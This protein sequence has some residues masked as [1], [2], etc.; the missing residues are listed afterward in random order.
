MVSLSTGDPHALVAPPT[1]TVPA[2]TSTGNFALTYPPT[3]KTANV[4]LTAHYEG[5]SVSTTVAVRA[6]PPISLALGASELARGVST[7]ATVT[8]NT[9]APADGAVVTLSS[10][11]SSA[12]TAPASVTL[13]AGAL[14]GSFTATGNYAGSP[15]TVTITAKYNGASASGS[16]DVPTTPVSRCT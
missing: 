10:T 13:P 8:L 3:N 1:V 4:T 14:T 12:V 2:G 7:T 5:S 6:W 11:D 9:P 15:K 16:V